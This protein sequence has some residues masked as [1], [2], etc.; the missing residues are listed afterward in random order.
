MILQRAMQRRYAFLIYKWKANRGM[1]NVESPHESRL[2]TLLHRWGWSEVGPE[3]RRRWAG[4]E[5][6]GGR[7]PQRT[8]GATQT[9]QMHHPS[10]PNAPSLGPSRPAEP[11]VGAPPPPHPSRSALTTHHSPLTTLLASPL[12]HHQR[13]HAILY[14]AP[15]SSHYVLP[16]LCT[17]LCERGQGGVSLEVSAEVAIRCVRFMDGEFRF[18][19]LGWIQ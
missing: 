9:P 14:S 8:P 16:W 1:K 15:Q 13:H 18:G 4:P 5:R 2:W 7:T 12:R 11:I 6:R 17:C 10:R 3:K 19:W